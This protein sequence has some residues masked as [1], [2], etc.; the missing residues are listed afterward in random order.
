MEKFRRSI[1]GELLFAVR[2]FLETAF[3]NFLAVVCRAFSVLFSRGDV[4]EI[5]DDDTFCKHHPA[6]SFLTFQ[7]VARYIDNH[8]RILP[9]LPPP[10]LSIL[11]FHAAQKLS[12]LS[13]EFSSYGKHT[14]RAFISWHFNSNFS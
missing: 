3:F 14:A 8:Q 7:L 6:K 12:S 5:S 10:L 11:L 4:R 9:K 13:V 2:K 1:V